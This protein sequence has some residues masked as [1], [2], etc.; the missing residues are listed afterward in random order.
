MV[1]LVML[2]ETRLVQVAFAAAFED[3]VV[4]ASVVLPLVDLEMLLEVGSTRKCL[5][6]LVALKRLIT[7]V[8]SLVSDEIAYL[9]EGG[10]AANKFTFVRLLFV[11]HAKVLLERR[12]LGEGLI[13]VLAKKSK[14][15]KSLTI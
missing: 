4:V 11:V 8:D 6:A 5:G 2:L 13:T 3:A 12:I 15:E 9:A 14:K 10:V 7:S 1:Y